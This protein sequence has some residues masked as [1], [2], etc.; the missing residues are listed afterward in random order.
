MDL[1]S[2]LALLEEALAARG[3][4]ALIL[5]SFGAPPE[6]S[7]NAPAP[8][9]QVRR[10][11]FRLALEPSLDELWGRLA[12]TRRTQI[13]RAQREGLV[14][15]KGHTRAEVDQLG[16]LIAGSAQRW[17]Q[18]HGQNFVTPPPEKLDRMARHLVEPGLATVYLAECAGGPL[19]GNL[20]GHFNGQ[21]YNL[22]AGSSPEGFKVGAASWLYWEIIKDLKEQ[23][24]REFNLGG[25]A[26]DGDAPNHPARG[27]YD[28]KRDFGG[29]L[30]SCPSLT[31]VM[32]PG[33]YRWY[34]CLKERKPP[35]SWTVFHNLF[36]KQSG[37]AQ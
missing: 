9:A 26:P 3:I 33:R 31:Y 7:S 28:F 32:R 19:S 36:R 10:A 8:F 6:D 34:Q 5:D 2:L 12:G 13:R 1:P 23:R 18:S 25:V 11:E 17:S 27:L 4:M 24:V 21:A 37:A 14:L 22:L 30:V 29:R 35:W 16:R 15:R 20:V